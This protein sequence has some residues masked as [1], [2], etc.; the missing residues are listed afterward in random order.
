VIAVFDTSPLHYLVL[1][2][3]IDL[4]PQLLPRALIPPVVRSELAAPGAPDPVRS[5]IERPPHWLQI[6][7][8]KGEPDSAVAGLHRGE[9]AVIQ[10]AREVAADLVVL[11]DKAARSVASALGMRITGLLGILDLAA[12]RGLVDL[13]AAVDRLRSTSFRVA[14]SLLHS[15][16]GRHRTR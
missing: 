12:Q 3:E 8:A 16:L 2:G 10:L 14:P 13:P 5:W 11:D 7:E 6:R 9:R 4:I 1:I 15:L